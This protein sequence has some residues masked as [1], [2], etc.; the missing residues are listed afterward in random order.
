MPEPQHYNWA[1]ERWDI[2]AGRW[3]LRPV[4]GLGQWKREYSHGSLKRDTIP[5]ID[6][7]TLL[8]AKL[9]S[10]VRFNNLNQSNDIIVKRF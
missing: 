6:Y 5:R 1:A 9:L 8:V 3:P 7:A 4:I 2:E 10:R